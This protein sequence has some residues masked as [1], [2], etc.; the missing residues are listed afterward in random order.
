M[1]WLQCVQ[2]RVL[3]SPSLWWRWSARCGRQSVLATRLSAVWL[4]IS[5][6]TLSTN[7][8]LLLPAE[9]TAVLF[10]A[11]T[12]CQHD[13]HK[14]LQLAWWNF[15]RTCALTSSRSLSIV[16]VI[17]QMS[18]SRGFSCVGNATGNEEPCSNLCLP[19]TANAFA[20]PASTKGCT[21]VAREHYLV[22][23]KAW[24]FSLSIVL[25]AIKQTTIRHCLFWNVKQCVSSSSF[26][27]A[28]CACTCLHI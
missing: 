22:L 13:T 18:R 15:A 17:G 9:A 7:S 6:N 1:S 8:L 28:H 10:S 27:T 24:W 3:R 14:P 11:L 5:V 4:N 23:S 19:K 21:D 2:C 25:H 12:L 16:K 20:W 26:C